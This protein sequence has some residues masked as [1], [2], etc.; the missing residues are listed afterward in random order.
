MGAEK[1]VMVT[2]RDRS[3]EV[4]RICDGDIIPGM[5]CQMSTTVGE[6]QVHGTP[7]GNAQTMFALEA[8][9]A[10]KDIDDALDDGENADFCIAATGS[11]VNALLAN[12]ETVL[13]SQPVESN[14]DGY[15]RPHD[16]VVNVPSDLSVD[17]FQSAIV[18]WAEETLDMSDSSGADPA[19][20][21]F[22]VR[23]R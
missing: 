16:S 8:T 23:V 6:V 13:Y 2:G 5:L 9:D 18:G 7:G 4:N 19:S 12:G 22:L 15:L 20:A 21:R 17:I 14:G 11:L 1:T 10:G 3:I